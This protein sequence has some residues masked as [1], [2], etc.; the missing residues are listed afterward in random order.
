MP[1]LKKILLVDDEPDM[2]LSTAQALELEG[3][4][5]EEASVNPILMVLLVGLGVALGVLVVEQ[6]RN[7]RKRP[8]L[9]AVRHLLA[10]ARGQL[11]QH[12]HDLCL[13]FRHHRRR[14]AQRVVPRRARSQRT[15]G[16]GHA[17]KKVEGVLT[18]L[19]HGPWRRQRSRER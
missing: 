4:E 18:Q 14:A 11:R 2:R 1:G 8:H 19:G 7:R 13:H 12:R 17:D 5:V 9:L 3:F 15:T 6:R 10:R 16:F